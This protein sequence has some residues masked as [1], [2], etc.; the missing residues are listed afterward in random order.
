MQPRATASGSHG[1]ASDHHASN[2]GGW[3]VRVPWSDRGATDGPA[4]CEPVVSRLVPCTSFVLPLHIPWVSVVRIS[5]FR[6]SNG[7]APTPFPFVLLV[8]PNIPQCGYRCCLWN[9]G[10]VTRLARIVN[11]LFT[12][13]KSYQHHKRFLSTSRRYA[14]INSVIPIQAGKKSV[15]PPC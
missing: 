9:C 4:C 12:I 6:R 13:F 2:L 3:R 11:R 15:Q 1:A 5:Q 10:T 8:G 14:M 7:S